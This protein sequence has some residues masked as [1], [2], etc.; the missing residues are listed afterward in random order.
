LNALAGGYSM[1]VIPPHAQSA[2]SGLWKEIEHVPGRHH[3]TRP[4]PI[5]LGGIAAALL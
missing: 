5:D 1:H 4:R 2:L 3:E